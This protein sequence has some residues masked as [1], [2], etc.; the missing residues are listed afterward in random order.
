MNM[1]MVMGVDVIEGQAGLTKGLK[2]RPDLGLRLATRQGAAVDLDAGAQEIAREAA[3]AADEL[4]HLLRRQ[5]RPTVHEHEM[6]SD[7]EPG[8]F[9]RALHSIGSG[10]CRYHEAGGSQDAAA[11]PNLHRLIDRESQTEIIGGDDQ[12]LHAATR[13]GFDISRA[14]ALPTWSE[15]RHLPP[16]CPHFEVCIVP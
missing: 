9:A 13:R 10:R 2:L 7:A 5:R 11:M 16:V 1:K 3:I 6:K 8:Q 4:R 12:P 14:R 15:A